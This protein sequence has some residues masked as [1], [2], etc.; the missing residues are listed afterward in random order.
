MKTLLSGAGAV[1]SDLGLVPLSN[2]LRH[3]SPGCSAFVPDRYS[4]VLFPRREFAVV[5]PSVSRHSGTDPLSGTHH[6]TKKPSP[7]CPPHRLE[8]ATAYVSEVHQPFSLRSDTR[9]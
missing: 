2:R 6:R 5:M 8:R 7:N 9:A 3:H 4:H 1:V